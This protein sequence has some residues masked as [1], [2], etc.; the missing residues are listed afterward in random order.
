MATDG[1]V[2]KLWRLLDGDR[3][4]AAS[5]RMTG[6]DEKTA[7]RYREDQRLPSHRKTKREYRTRLDPFGDVW[8]E[9][10]E[11]LEAEPKLA[12]EKST[13]FRKE[14]DQL[15]RTLRKTP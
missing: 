8:T 15:S 2:R 14:V 11:R 3:S 9:V 12:M 6:M 1:Q 10:Q 7:H 4:L 5:A 13:T